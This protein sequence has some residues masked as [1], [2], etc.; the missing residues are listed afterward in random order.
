MV[1][2]YCGSEIEAGTKYCPHCGQRLDD[3]TQDMTDS[4]Q[5]PISTGGNYQVKAVDPPVR[6]ATAHAGSIVLIIAAAAAALLALGAIMFFISSGKRS[7]S[8]EPAAV[9]QLMKKDGKLVSEI[10]EKGRAAIEEYDDYSE[11][12]NEKD[13]RWKECRLWCLYYIDSKEK[14]KDSLIMVFKNAFQNRK[15]KWNEKEYKYDDVWKTEKKYTFIGISVPYSGGSIPDI[16]PDDI[17]DPYEGEELKDIES[18]IED[19]NDGC[20]IYLLDTEQKESRDKA[21]DKD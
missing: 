2:K 4:G 11:F 12:F 17:D 21:D 14:D 1:C 10:A 3:G 15:T 18:S 6:A 20:T 9:K 16:D 7:I 19:D 8:G 13:K 5:V